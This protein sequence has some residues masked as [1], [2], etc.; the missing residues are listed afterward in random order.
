MVPLSSRARSTFVSRRVGNYQIHPAAGST[1]RPALGAP[2]AALGEGPQALHKAAPEAPRAIRNTVEMTD[3]LLH[4]T[5]HETVRIIS[6]LPGELAVEAA[7]GPGGSPPPPHLHPA[8]D[9]HF[10]VKS[11]QLLAV[12]DGQKRT[13]APGDT[14]DIPR[15]TVHKMWNPGAVETTASW[16]TKPA[17]RTADWFRAID[18]IT[19]GGKR[20]PPLP[21]LAKAITAYSDEFRPLVRPKQLQPF[22]RVLFRALA[23]ADR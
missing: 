1:A 5:A 23:L 14:L 18:R 19:N 8:Q 20:K 2:G 4:L 22:V 15:G 17:L 9:E 10:E 21:P 13:L 7:W 16:S 12:L 6:E 11:G 3:Q